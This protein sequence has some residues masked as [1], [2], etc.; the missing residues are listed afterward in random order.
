M[1]SCEY[2]TTSGKKKTKKLTVNDTYFY[3]GRKEIK[4]TK[5]NLHLLHTATS[6]SVTFTLQK[7]NQRYDTITQHRSGHEIDPV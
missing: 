6:V 1:R 4:K 2:S 7:N 5:E 3:T